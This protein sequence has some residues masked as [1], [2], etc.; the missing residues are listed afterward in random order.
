MLQKVLVSSGRGDM[1]SF[2]LFPHAEQPVLLA[3]WEALPALRRSTWMK[4]GTLK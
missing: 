2:V 3:L 1:L 4:K